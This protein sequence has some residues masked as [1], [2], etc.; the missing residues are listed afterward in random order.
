MTSPVRK[1]KPTL[2]EVLNSRDAA[3]L[4]KLRVCSPGRVK[5]MRG[6]DP[7]RADIELGTKDEYKDG[8]ILPAPI[9]TSVPVVWPTANAG[10]AF[11]RMPL[12]VGD[13]GLLV[14]GDRSLDLWLKGIGAPVNPKD[15]RTHD[16][17]DAIFVPGLTTDSRTVIGKFGVPGYH[18]DTVM[19]GNG[20]MTITLDKTGKITIQGATGEVMQVLITAFTALAAATDMFAGL[21]L[22]SA[23]AMATA[24]TDLTNLKGA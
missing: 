23:A 4:S 21:P 14:F 6:N 11:L 3:L 2:A 1:Q 7:M 22:S 19:L 17:T 12:A 13:T 8:V 15:S 5:T 24:A 18:G 10:Q 20:S 9:I 16:L